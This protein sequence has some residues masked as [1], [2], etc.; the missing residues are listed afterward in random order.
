MYER[1]DDGIQDPR[2]GQDDGTKLSV[3]EKVRLL[4]LPFRHRGS[5]DIYLSISFI[6]PMFHLNRKP[7]PPS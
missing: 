4:W 6:Q 1:A 7:R 2:D 3:I 5:S